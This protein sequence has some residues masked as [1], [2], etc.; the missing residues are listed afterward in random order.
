MISP[1]I[2]TKNRRRNYLRLPL[3]KKMMNPLDEI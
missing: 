2:T 1:S 3:K